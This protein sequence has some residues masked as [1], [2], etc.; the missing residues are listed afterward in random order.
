[1]DVPTYPKGLADSSPN[2]PP[3]PPAGFELR[4]RRFYDMWPGTEGRDV[5]ALIL[6]STDVAGGR[7]VA[8]SHLSFDPQDGSANST[9]NN[10]TTARCSSPEPAPLPRPEDEARLLALRD[11]APW[12]SPSLPAAAVV[13]AS[14]ALMTPAATVPCAGERWRLVDGGCFEN[15]G[16]TTAF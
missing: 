16:L 5:P 2:P 10:K 3:K 12:L 13:S 6:L 11:A 7:R 9:D 4:T 14:V 1:K 8:I 15:S